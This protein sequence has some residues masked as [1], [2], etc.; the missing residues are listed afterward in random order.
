MVSAP[1]HSDPIPFIT[2]PN[3]VKAAAQC[4]FNIQPVFESLGIDTDLLH[5]ET[6]TIERHQLEQAMER[7]VA[8]ARRQH[9][10]F[11][12]GETFAFDYLPDLETFLTTSPRLREALHVFGWVRTLI[13]PML[14]IRLHEDAE[15]ARLVL[16][17]VP[18][19][20]MGALRPWFSETTFATVLK[21]GRMLLGNAAPWL[22]LHFRHPAPPHA[23]AYEPFFGI[24]VRFAQPEYAL[25]F[26]RAL[27]DQPLPGAYPALHAQARQRI[28][29]RLRTLP[30]PGLAGRIERRFLEHPTLLTQGVE[31]MASA[32]DLHPRALQRR[33]KTEGVG[34]E[35]LRA[36]QREAL[37]K[38]YLA[39]AEMTVEQVSEQL[40]FS[41]RRSFTRAFTR[42]TG[43]S[44]SQWRRQQDA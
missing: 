33:L 2:L 24:P 31:A 41:D 17:F 15:H 39:T 30:R 7:C 25:L 23:H 18:D 29:R 5:V 1:P 28:D 35:S 21:F 43:T 42:W 6:A 16:H 11:V 4:G 36:Q 10:P 12:L 3:W 32:L 37:A 20:Q 40:G 13:N 22:Q 8:L 38:Q 19:P 9:F 44:P 34:F 14:D 26:P 27:L